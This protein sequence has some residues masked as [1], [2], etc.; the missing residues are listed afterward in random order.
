MVVVV[1]AKQWGRPVTRKRLNAHTHAFVFLGIHIR[2]RARDDDD[3]NKLVAAAL[4][5]AL[6]AAAVAVAEAHF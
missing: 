6:P 4:R 2:R 1:P 5:H 3:I